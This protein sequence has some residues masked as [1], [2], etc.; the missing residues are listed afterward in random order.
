[1]SGAALFRIAPLDATHDRAVFSCGAPALDRYLREQA[2]QDI[3][4]RAA[5]CFVALSQE[6]RIAGYYTVSS[7]GVALVDLPDATRKRLPRYPVVPAVRMGRLAVDQ[8][9]QGQRLGGTLLVDAMRRAARSEIAAA[10]MVVDA[11][12]AHAAD[13]YRHHGFIPLLANA[14]TLYLPLATVAR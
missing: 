9:F 4:R 2:T 8:S 13:F 7:A 5:S 11:K 12:D 3:R 1:M 10:V 6:T 14:L